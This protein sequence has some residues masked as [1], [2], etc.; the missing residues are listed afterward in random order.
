MCEEIKKYK[1]S[2]DNNFNDYFNV[3]EIDKDAQNLLFQIYSNKDYKLGEYNGGA[4]PIIDIAKIMGFSIFTANFDDA[5]LSGT[6]GISKELVETYGSDKVIIL[7]KQDTD[8]HILFTIA[9][10][11]AH[12]IYDYRYVDC[13]ETGYSNTYRTDE[14]QN[15]KELRANRFAAAFL[16]PQNAFKEQYT[17]NNLN[18]EQL[19]IHFRVPLTAARLRIQELELN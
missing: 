15:D 8:E 10:E 2:H 6:I 1:A 19:A 18:A 17:K 9:H 11:L 4:V 12:Y 5:N 13:E 3:K 14:L 16:M 7:N